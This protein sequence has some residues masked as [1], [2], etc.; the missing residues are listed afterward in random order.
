[1]M[2]RPVHNNP[3]KWLILIGCVLGL[4]IMGAPAINAQT[5]GSIYG[6]VTDQ[7]GAVVTGG[8]VTVANPGTSLK[9]TATTDAKGAYIFPVLPVGVYDMAV[10]AQGFK[11]YEQRGL[12]L[13]VEANLRV[14][15]KLE[16]GQITERVVV[17]TET[18]Q[19]DTASATLGKVVEEKR[20]VELPL[21]GRNFLQLGLLQAGVTPPIA[22]IDV[23]GSGTNSTPGGTKFNFSVNGMRPISNN[24]LLDGVNNVE[25]MSGSAMI[26]PSADGIQEFRILTNSYS[27]DFGRAGGS[28][29]T[30]IT[31]RGSNSYHGSAYEFL[32]NDYFDARNFF[33]P[34]VPALKQNQFGGTFGGPIIKDKT[35]FFGGYEGFRQIAG[36]ATSTTVPSLLVRQ[37]DFSQEAVKPLDPLTG[38]PFPGNRIPEGRINPVAARL[39]TLWP[40]PNQGSNIW[41]GAPTNSNDRN[42][43][44]VRIDHSLMEGK[45]SLTGR[46][47]IDQGSLS[48][49]K[50]G[51]TSPIGSIDVPGFGFADSSRFQN[52]M[53]ADTHI[54]SPEIINDFRFSYQRAKVKAGFPVDPADPQNF[55]FTYPQPASVAV[56]PQIVLFGTSS[57]G[58]TIFNSRLSNFY[59]FVDNL[60]VS[61]G[62]HSMKLGA[63]VRRTNVFGLFPSLS[64]GTFQFNGTVTGNP[65][66][67]FLLGRS[68]VFSQVGGRE[69]KNI[70]QTAAYFYF[71]DDFHV[72]RNLTLNLGLRYE[73][74][75]GYKEKDNLLTT[76]VPGVQSTVSP[77]LPPGLLR[78]GDPGI[79]ETL[80]PTG[81][82]D[83]A[84]RF[85]LA[86][87]P[88]GDGKTSVRAGYG[89]FYD[90]SALVQ[91]FTVQQPPDF[92]PF[93]VQLSP[94]SLADPYSGNSP[95]RPPVQFPLPL[96]PGFTV[97]LLAPDFKLAYIQHWNLTLQRQL[98]PSL[99]VEVAYVGNKGTHLQGDMDPNQAIWSPGA[100][101]AGANLR[102][103]R[104]Y[105]P[106]GRIFQISSIFNSNYNGLQSTLTQRLHGGLSFQASYTWSK[107]IDDVSKPTSF[108]RMPGQVGRPQDSRNLQ[109]ERGLS[110][111][112]VRH[113][114]VLSYI[115]EFPF[116]KQRGG[117]VSSVLGGWRLSGITSL[118][119]GSPFSVLDTSDP[120][121]DGT[122]DNDRPDVIRNPNLPS[123]QRTPERW[124]DTAAFV[125]FVA[126]AN[127][128]T[129]AFGTEGRNILTTDGIINF[130]AGLAKDV[131]LGENRRLELRWEVFNLFN[132]PNFGVPINDLNAS[133]FGRVLKTS[134]P[135]RQ[136]Q[137][138]L[139]FIF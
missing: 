65:L 107:A 105:N 139:K 7:S 34:G 122:P 28:I 38:L 92:Q 16:V 113:R 56:I 125:R 136:M 135:E 99:A 62:K 137:F 119:S 87:D 110:A 88:F 12:E 117:F 124:F 39:L 15:F 32:R 131:S 5:T 80:F 111:F 33:S 3:N 11:P 130:D 66:G 21:N 61:K 132:H 115:Y 77:S 9:R 133:N 114:F 96:S 95:F 49:P 26:V 121:L 19:I 2:I 94:A 123:G 109:A 91:Q 31:R 35:F 36:L 84:P 129:P 51:S 89:I 60:V 102:G 43:F 127:R 8:S 98:T 68:S 101:L 30:V 46:Y 112:D 73:R 64:F 55:G 40:A 47:L 10:E 120:G 71:Q 90:D 103:R 108:F 82:L 29:V 44:M 78:P 116:F 37:G 20:I 83:F 76:F 69:D 45:N 25:P 128:L 97:G 50:G 81:K 100:S 59:D 42:Q 4:F 75:P 41:T 13:Q 17:T 48:T 18:P 63:E 6:S 93:F 67:D 54:F 52:F 79:P 138:A 57:L 86:W 22:G 104:P 74:V 126:S 14:D 85:G 23:V 72:T 53:V 27:A 70:K 1:M 106:I 118:Q 58:Y 24:H 134:T